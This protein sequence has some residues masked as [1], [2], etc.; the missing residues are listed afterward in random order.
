MGMWVVICVLFA[1]DFI[2]S[3]KS[4]TPP[5]T[6]DTAI[7][8]LIMIASVILLSAIGIFLNGIRDRLFPKGV[9]LI[10]QEK[11]LP[12]P[13]KSS[14]GGCHC[15]GVDSR[16]HSCRWIVVLLASLAS[17]LPLRPALAG[18]GIVGGRGLHVG[19]ALAFPIFL[20]LLPVIG[21]IVFAASAPARGKLILALGLIIAIAIP[22]GVNS[23]FV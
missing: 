11:P 20:R 6:K 17:G 5:E 7:A 14:V 10:G 16:E 8:Q 15:L 1:F 18:I 9:F 12:Y 13:R 23:P 19:P 4:T 21:P 2:Q 3:S 22:F